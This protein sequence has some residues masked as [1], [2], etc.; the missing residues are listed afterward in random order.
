MPKILATMLKSDA[1]N[2]FGSPSQTADAI[3]ITVQSVSDW[4]A[5]LPRRI[6]DR[7]IAAAVRM[8]REVPPEFLNKPLEH[9]STGQQK[10]AA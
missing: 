10:V 8:G 1:I 9:D 6:A 5:T 7:V 4:P 3:G 2:F